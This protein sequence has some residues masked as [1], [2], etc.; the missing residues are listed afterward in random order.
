MVGRVRAG[1]RPANFVVVLLV[2]SSSFAFAGPIPDAGDYQFVSS[3]PDNSVAGTF[4]SDGT[5][6]T[7]WNFRAFEDIWSDTTS[8]QFE[9]VNDAVHFSA[10]Y[11]GEACEILPKGQCFNYLQELRW[12]TKVVTSCH[13]D[14]TQ[15]ASA[16]FEYQAVHFFT[17]GFETGD[18]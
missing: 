16:T 5:K 14:N 18:D 3:N 9:S 7:A 4:T 8:Y 2:L 17:D 11:G 1:Q 15:C 10:V 6:L 12:D 13:F